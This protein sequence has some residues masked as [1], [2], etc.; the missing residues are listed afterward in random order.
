MT[1]YYNEIDAFAAAWLR[2]LIAA[3]HIASGDVDERSIIDVSPDDLK[4]YTQCHFFAGI[5]VWSYALRLSRW[6]DDRPVWTGSCPCQPFSAA[7]KGKGFDD[8]RHLWPAWFYLINQC[9]PSV[10]FGEQVASKDGLSWLDLVHADLEGA[11]YA[12][13]PFDL[14]AAG[15]GAP[16]IRQ[17]LYFV[18]ELENAIGFGSGGRGDGDPP[19]LRGEIQ[20]QGRS[21][22]GTL[23][24]TEDGGC[25]GRELGDKAGAEC[26]SSGSRKDEGG[27]RHD[28]S[29]DV[30]HGRMADPDIARCEKQ[31]DAG[32]AGIQREAIPPQ[33]QRERSGDFCTVSGELAN[34]DGKQNYAAD[35][36]GFFSKSCGNGTEGALA[37]SGSQHDG[38]AYAAS[39]RRKRQRK[40][41]AH[42]ERREAR[43]EPFGI[44]ESGFEGCPL[45]DQCGA[46]GLEFCELADTDNPR[47]QGRIRGRQNSGRE[48]QHRHAG[49]HGAVD[50]L[51]DPALR[52][53]EQF[54]EQIGHEREKDQGRPCDGCGNCSDALHSGPSNGF[55]RNADWIWCRDG[56]WR[57][58]ESG[59]FPLAYG[60]TNRVGRL[61]AYGNAIVAQAAQEII[62]AYMEWRLLHKRDQ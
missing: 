41:A 45:P 59:T 33:G 7:G 8:E 17:R 36:G 5:G 50:E 21:A 49:C 1:A 57:A 40:T 29:D 3:G 2:N 10:V 24:N 20:A 42:E 32:T 52:R 43:S 16:H 55:W 13:A 62:S 39:D 37:C 15:V 4:G 12:I 38:M 47:S 18:G 44:V 53:C 26:S 23:G 58:V 22:S 61:R 35:A 48:D 27:G 25:F 30:E 14:C 51:A 54:S 46:A 11:D 56:R 31:P 6:P 19:E 28:A 34:P 60:I 9:R